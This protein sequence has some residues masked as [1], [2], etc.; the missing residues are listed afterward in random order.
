[1]IVVAGVSHRMAPL[2][3]RERCAV[4]A[5]AQDGVRAALA[6]RFG[7]CMLLSTCGRTELYTDAAEA[8]APAA[9]AA[10]AAW[11]AARAGAAPPSATTLIET[12]SGDDAL[13]RLLRVACGLDSALEGEDEILGQVRRAWLGA[14]LAG[15]LTPA[16]DAACR[17]AVRTGRRARRQESGQAWTSLADW[18]A[19]RIAG[20]VEGQRRPRVLVAGTGPMGL[21][22]AE[23]LR[24]RFG[25]A[26]DLTLAGRTLAHVTAHAA[27]F[28]ARPVLLAALPVVLCR[29][30]A[31]VVAL[32]TRTPLIDAHS[33]CPRPP[34]R[35]LVLVDLSLP[36]AVDTSVGCLANV[37]LVDLD[38]LAESAQGASRWDSEGRANVERL[39]EDAVQ[40]FAMQSERSETAETLTT[41]RIQ[42]DRIRRSQLARTFRRLPHLDPETRWAVDAMTR[43]IV[44]RLLHSPTQRLKG[45]SADE[46]AAR[47]R[48]LFG[49]E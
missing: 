45:E 16:L 13:R 6:Q 18:A 10:L 27:R 2:A 30:D 37:T 17:L 32:R 8:D 11:L 22:A 29:A 4:P 39:V 24:G 5:E 14:G 47:I 12:A 44:N 20:V 26:L 42:A 23:T 36:R 48:R 40:A 25:G 28:D 31:A 43:A 9:A 46:D 35:P 21:R 15:T 1:M 49:F 34:E 19:A 38:S 7:A 33:V 3:F 41:L